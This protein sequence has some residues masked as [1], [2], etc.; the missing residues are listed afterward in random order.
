MYFGEKRNIGSIH[1]QIRSNMRAR[2]RENEASVDEKEVIE[3]S[4]FSIRLKTLKLTDRRLTIVAIHSTSNVFG[5]SKRDYHWFFVVYRE[6]KI[7]QIY[8]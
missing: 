2:E 1:R 6:E 3:N 7:L 8:S 4:E 5:I